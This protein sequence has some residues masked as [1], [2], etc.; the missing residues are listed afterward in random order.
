MD[1]QTAHRYGIGQGLRRNLRR[2]PRPSQT[3]PFAGGPGALQQPDYWRRLAASAHE[4]AS[5]E[6][7]ERVQRYPSGLTAGDPVSPQRA[8]TVNQSKEPA[9]PSWA[10]T[11]RGWSAGVAVDVF[12]HY[13]RPL[14]SVRCDGVP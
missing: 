11:R 14:T 2:V 10:V 9:A 8:D 4:P 3:H 6:Q 13:L 5:Q 12:A 1:Q 7:P